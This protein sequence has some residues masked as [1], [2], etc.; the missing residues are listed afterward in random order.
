VH[1]TR[2]QFQHAMRHELIEAVARLSGRRVVAFIS[3]HHAGPD[4]AVER[5]SLEGAGP[6]SP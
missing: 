3:N 1:E 4:L 5:F 2:G 6:P